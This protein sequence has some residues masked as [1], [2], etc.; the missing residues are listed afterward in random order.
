MC[1]QRVEQDE[2]RVVD[3]R[4][5]CIAVAWAQAAAAPTAT[6]MA[7]RAT[8]TCAPKTEKRS[9]RSTKGSGPVKLAMSR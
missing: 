4:T 2:P 5:E 1:S 3:A 7:A 9:S 8:P 6:A